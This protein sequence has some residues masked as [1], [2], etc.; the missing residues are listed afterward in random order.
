MCSV[1]NHASD[2]VLIG[3]SKLLIQGGEIQIFSRP[4]EDPFADSRWIE[5]GV[6][7]SRDIDEDDGCRQKR[8]RTASCRK[9]ISVR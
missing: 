6:P 7:P 2:R 9:Q 8:R 5:F 3:C 4:W 1:E